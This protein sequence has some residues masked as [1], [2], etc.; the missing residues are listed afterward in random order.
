MIMEKEKISLSLKPRRSFW[1]RYRKVLGEALFS[2]LCTVA[3]V[4]LVFA[5]TPGTALYEG[6]VNWLSGHDWLAALKELPGRL[7][8]TGIITLGA[9]VI[10]VVV[11]LPLALGMADQDFGY[12][13]VAV[14]AERASHPRLRKLLRGA[15]R[16]AKFLVR[17]GYRLLAAISAIPVF[18]LS[19]LCYEFFFHLR[20]HIPSFSSFTFFWQAAILVPLFAVAFGDG[21]LSDLVRTFQA[22]ITNVCK[23]NYMRAALA[24]GV[25]VERHLW[26]NTVIPLANALSSQIVV[27]L[28]GAVIVEIIFKLPGIGL[29][30]YDIAAYARNDPVS[31]LSM[32]SIAVSIVTVVNIFHF[33]NHW[34][35]LKFDPKAF[36]AMQGLDENQNQAQ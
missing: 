18:F 3:L 17:P 35:Q 11:A 24:R 22:E 14:S 32:L 30:A 23:E 4:I 28:G 27:L 1:Q 6:Q 26:R 21:L 12:L 34:L 7:W 20:G 19:Y 33:L 15:R 2:I 5:F 31:F 9:I 36:K 13:G 10:A 8:R 29:W 16:V 25:P